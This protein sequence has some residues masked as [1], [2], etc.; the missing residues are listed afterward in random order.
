MPRRCRGTRW[1]RFRCSDAVSASGRVLSPERGPHFSDR[2][3]TLVDTFDYTA[4][5]LAI[6]KVKIAFRLA[7]SLLD[8]LAF[9]V[10]HYFALQVAEHSVSFRT[11]WY[12]D[13]KKAKGIRIDLPIENMALRGLFWLAKDLSEN[14]PGFIHALEPDARQVAQIRNNLEHK[15]LKVHEFGIS[16][17]RSS[18][19]GDGVDA[20]T[21]LAYSV[22]RTEFERMTLRLLKTVRCA[23]IYTTFAI[24]LEETRRRAVEPP[25]RR[26]VP[27]PTSTVPHKFKW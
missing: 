21:K 25:H 2:D 19:E 12:T 13:Q 6:E 8:K 7:Y 26:I 23:L 16:P 3:V 9:L 24:R 5:S 17:P 1:R 27:F 22:S 15:Y 10:N 14:H 4:Y 18:I 20:H 11:I